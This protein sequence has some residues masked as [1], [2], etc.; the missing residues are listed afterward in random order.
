LII[1]HLELKTSF[2]SFKSAASYFKCGGF[3]LI[4]NNL[5]LK[6]PLQSFTS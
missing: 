5:E 3:S 2:Q 1:N 4:I 6:T